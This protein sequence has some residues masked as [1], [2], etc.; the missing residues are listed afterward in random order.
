M[1]G[2][3][4]DAASQERVYPVGNGGL[5]RRL[6]DTRDLGWLQKNWVGNHG[7]G[8]QQPVVTLSLEGSDR[9]QF[10]STGEGVITFL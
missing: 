7:A 9:S 1:A 2:L 8:A 5:P 3:R 6:R 10:R 4:L